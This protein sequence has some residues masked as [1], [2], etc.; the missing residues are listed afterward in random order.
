MSTQEDLKTFDLSAAMAALKMSVETRTG[1]KQ[2][3]LRGPQAN[4]GEKGD[5]GVC[6]C[7]E[8]RDGKDG[9]D[10]RPGVDGK[11]LEL[12]IG[13]VTTGDNA[14]AFFRRDANGV[15]VLNLTL[16]R[17]ECGERG[18]A[19]TVPGP[20]G[21]PGKAGIDAVAPTQQEIERIVRKVLEANPEKFRGQVGPAGESVVG[22]K[23]DSGMGREEIK[24]LIVQILADAG[25][26][27]EQAQ[28][29]VAI[30]VKL[31]N[32]IH[33]ADARHIALVSDIIRDVDKLF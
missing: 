32:A 10:G 22:P 24:Y 20:T 14:A 6:V 5:P 8:P 27:S 29:L 21:R 17:G 7:R 12:V 25:V 4:R 28:K 16:P 33:A 15:Y 2:E 13:S 31:H 9:A 1:E 3:Q 30:R 26:L 19:S 23:G 18:A 11:T